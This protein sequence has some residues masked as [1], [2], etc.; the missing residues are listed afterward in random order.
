MIKFHNN[1][2][3]LICGAQEV[4]N[5]YQMSKHREKRCRFIETLNKYIYNTIKI[6]NFLTMKKRLKRFHLYICIS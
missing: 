2:Y 5:R 3:Y 1:R 4:A 6:M